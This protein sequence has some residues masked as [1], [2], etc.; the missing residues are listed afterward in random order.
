MRYLITG[1]AGFI[2]GHLTESL[3]ADGHEVVV[4]DDLSTGSLD[5]LAKV[6]DNPR[7]DFV[8]G[9]ILNL[10][11]LEYLITRSDMVF[12]LAAAVGVELVVHDPVRTI[13]TNVH[14]TEKVLKGAARKNVKTLV[15]STSE[16][17]GKSNNDEFS[18]TD[19]LLI[20]PSVKSRWSYACSKL[21][22]EFYAMAQHKSN[23][24][25]VIVTRFFNTVGPRQTGQYGMV[26]PRFVARALK[27]EPLL[28]Y[29]DGEQSRCFCHVFDT[30]R[31]LRGLA[32]S[33]R[34]VGAVVNVGTRHSTTINA[35]AELVVSRLGSSSTIEHIPYE[36]A[37]EAGF[38][39][40]RRRMPNTT[41]IKSLIGW[42]PTL[43]L[44]EII[45][46]VAASLK[47]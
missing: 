43:S 27:G 33:E 23:G 11:E 25:P 34:A 26:L 2:G 12:H 1:G 8:E 6:A 14:G 9:D 28:V 42:E 44:E 5:N 7:L 29:G 19:D 13:V 30:V 39:D 37:Y 46:D 45:D 31:A 36:E 15:A 32:D 21:L 17:Y 47:V 40:M 16:V 4:I 24:L 38:E 18:E 10:P 41:A 3:L 20:G 22:D 35:L